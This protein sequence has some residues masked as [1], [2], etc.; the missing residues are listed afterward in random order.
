MDE[1]VK[2]VFEMKFEL[3]NEEKDEET[4]EN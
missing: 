4:E 3:D 1:E 2:K